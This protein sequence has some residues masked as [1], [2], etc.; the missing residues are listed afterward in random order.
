MKP[1]YLKPLKAAVF[2]D[3]FSKSRLL[4]Q[5]ETWPELP[6][7]TSQALNSAYMKGDRAAAQMTGNTADQHY[8]DEEVLV[9]V[10][11][12]D[13]VYVVTMRRLRGIF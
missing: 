5:A 9:A 12:A 8:T 2:V 1:G 13:L 3:P 11:K 10:N 6:A 7:H 4:C